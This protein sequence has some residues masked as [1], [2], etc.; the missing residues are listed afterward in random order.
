MYKLERTHAQL[1]VIHSDIAG[2][3]PSKPPATRPTEITI[4]TCDEDCENE[5]NESDGPPPLSPEDPAVKVLLEVK[6]PDITPGIPQKNSY[7]L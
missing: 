5:G 2:G 3:S 1:V 7:I 6:S 4:T